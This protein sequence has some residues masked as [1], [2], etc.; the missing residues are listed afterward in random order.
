MVFWSCV[1]DPKIHLKRTTYIW[2]YLQA[3]YS[4]HLKSV[5]I[6]FPFFF[7]DRIVGIK[8]WTAS[9]KIIILNLTVSKYLSSNNF[10]IVY[11]KFPLVISKICKRQINKFILLFYT[12]WNIQRKYGIIYIVIV[13][14]RR[15]D[16]LF[17]FADFDFW[18][19][20]KVCRD[21]QI[22]KPWTHF[23]ICWPSSW[24]S[25]SNTYLAL[26]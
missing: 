4:I 8:F 13:E 9:L 20:L 15:V 2:P 18:P 11:V 6:G 24:Q 1:E 26:L 5:I 22:L 10:T 16:L 3:L 19:S 21:G 25:T 14:K 17:L 23:G 7:P 12:T